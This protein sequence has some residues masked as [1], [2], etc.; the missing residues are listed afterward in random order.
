MPKVYTR[1][2]ADY[3]LRFVSRVCR[4]LV[5]D[6]VTFKECRVVAQF[7]LLY[8][9]KTCSSHISALAIVNTGRTSYSEL[10]RLVEFWN[11]YLDRSVIKCFTI[12]DYKLGILRNKLFKLC[13][14]G[15]STTLKEMGSLENDLKQ[16]KVLVMKRSGLSSTQFF[17][18]SSLHTNNISM[19]CVNRARSRKELFFNSFLSLLLSTCVKLNFIN[20]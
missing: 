11:V 4:K 12:T 18:F 19:E 7:N 15:P 5:I 13:G 6:M 9:S 14:C 1:I 20:A 3:S 16:S 2:I 17:S 10:R 8:L